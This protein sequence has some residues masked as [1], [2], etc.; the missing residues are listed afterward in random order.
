MTDFVDPTRDPHPG[1]SVDLA[2]VAEWTATDY[3][4]YFRMVDKAPPPTSEFWLV[5]G[6]LIGYAARLE[7]R[8]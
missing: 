6:S 2:N 4:R 7:A 1:F 3:F 8:R 5:L